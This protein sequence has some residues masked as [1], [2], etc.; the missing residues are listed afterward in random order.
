[1]TGIRLLIN[2]ARQQIIKITVVYNTILTMV[3]KPIHSS[4]SAVFEQELFSCFESV[5][6]HP[7]SW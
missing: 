7:T 2:Y 6:A 3:N 4:I 1:M 5:V